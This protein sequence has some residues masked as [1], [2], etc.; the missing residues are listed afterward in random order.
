VVHGVKGDRAAKL[1][2]MCPSCR[3]A[4][5]RSTITSSHCEDSCSAGTM[6]TANPAAVHREKGVNTL[7]AKPGRPYLLIVIRQLLLMSGD[8]ELNPGPQDGECR[9]PFVCQ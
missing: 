2:R 8:V 5:H 1:R 6:T 7:K 4:D 9:V 3:E